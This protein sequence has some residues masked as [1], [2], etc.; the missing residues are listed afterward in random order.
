MLR[1]EGIVLNEMKYKESSKI[2]NIF[3]RNLGKITVMAQGAYRPKSTLIGNTQIFNLC[4]YNLRKGRNF[5]YING[6]DLIESNYSIRENMDR[7][8]YGFYMLELLDKSTP[9]EE[10]HE[11]LFLLLKKGLSVLSA[12]DK[13]YLKFIA[14]YESKFISFLGYR[15]HLSSCVNCNNELNGKLK[16]SN[17]HGGIICSD[18]F[19]LDIVAKFVDYQFINGLNALILTSLDELEEL[20]INNNILGKIHE[21]LLDYILENIDRKEFKSLNIINTMGEF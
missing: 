17:I 4:E 21:I 2:L 18:C 1:T 16:F 14:A 13:D 9:I 12:L 10:E 7:M 5:Y 3:T 6:A 20:N 11:K 15:P 8:I 19:S